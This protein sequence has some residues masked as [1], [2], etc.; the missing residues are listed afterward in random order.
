MRNV[1]NYPFQ[2][3]IKKGTEKVTFL[4]ILSDAS[5]QPNTFV[6]PKQYLGKPR[7]CIT[8]KNDSMFKEGNNTIKSKLKENTNTRET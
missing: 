1:K 2:F 3:K 7:R 4:N 8:I 5:D 6:E